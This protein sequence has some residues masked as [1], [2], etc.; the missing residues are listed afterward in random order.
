MAAESGSLQ[1][2]F[3]DALAHEPGADREAYLDRACAG[4]AHLRARLER[5]LA[6]HESAGDFMSAPAT[7]PPPEETPG[8]Q[9]GRYHLLEQIGEGGFG[10]V[11]M[12][13]QTSPVRRRV[14]L[15]IIKLGMDTKQVV[16]RFEAE[17]QALAMMEH[18]NIARVIDA[19]ATNT[20]RPYFVME[21]VKGI[22]ITTYC[23]QEK[24]STRQRLDLF[25]TVCQA[26]EHAHQR[27]II[28]RD[29]K[30]S[31]VMVTVRDGKAVPKVIDFGI[32]KATQA[33][34]TE[35]TLF[36][37]FRQL[38]GT[39]AYMSPEQAD[40][41][42][43]DADTRSDVYSLGVLL[44]ELLTG[45][46]PFDPKEL[47]SAAYD[48]MRRIIREVDPPTP[49]TRLGLNKDTL[50]SVAACRGIE[51]RKLAAVLRGDLDWIVMRSLEKDRDRRY[52]SADALVRDLRR[53][54]DN[55][56]VE[57]RRPTRAYRLRKFIRRN[58][59][60]VLAVTAVVSALLIGSTLATIGLIKA[61]RGERAARTEAIRAEQVAKFLEEMIKG[62]EPAVARGRDTS[63]LRE[64][65]D[66]TAGRVERE[67]QD[68]PLVQGNLWHT[69]ALAY[70]AIGDKKRQA[71][72]LE[73]A[74]E[75]FRA[76]V[77]EVHAKTAVATAQLG[78]TYSVLGDNVK[79]KAIA[80]R[81]VDIARKLNNRDTL[82]TC[83]FNLA[84]ACGK[85]GMGS[86]DA[87]PY[88]REAVELRRQG[89]SPVALADA[90]YYEAFM[91]SESEDSSAILR[92]AL[93][94]HRQ[95]LSN[96][97]PKVASD[98]FLLGQGQLASHQ[99][100]EAAQTLHA[101][102]DLWIKLYDVKHPNRCI[103]ARFYVQALLTAGRF[104][105]AE[106]VVQKERQA[107]PADGGYWNLLVLAKLARG[108]LQAAMEESARA[109]EAHPNT[110]I[111]RHTRAVTALRAGD[112]EEYR[113]VCAAFLQGNRIHYIGQYHPA[114]IA[115]LLP[116]DGKDFERVC[117]IADALGPEP[118]PKHELDGKLAR[119]LADLRRGRFDSAAQWADT[120]ICDCNCHC[121]EEAQGDFIA[122]LAHAGARRGDDARAAFNRGDS[123]LA[124][125]HT[126]I[127]GVIHQG[128]YGNL[129]IANLLRGEAAA[130]LAKLPPPSA[131]TT[132]TTT[133]TTRP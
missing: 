104:D 91:L 121:L 113:R 111:I 55:E 85:Y 5:L 96:D 60:A 123:L 124:L 81:G 94:I 76:S 53:H 132:T 84:S 1:A 43:A 15:K 30:P 51:P 83:L 78:F 64:I 32:A 24:L 61:R 6:A 116:V 79:G 40:T 74:I 103:V 41:L 130:A 28:H 69:L 133:A 90:L 38:I 33:R 80:Q 115:L 95:H 29:L 66:K 87:A 58:R 57:A 72:L 56:P 10:I 49:S 21:L 68:Q 120:V 42:A 52:Q 63:V 93:A 2:L 75:R 101:A 67:L 109:L 122:A 108:D 16:A 3:A 13:E 39:P 128:G 65:L 105:E 47:M 8:S 44:Y 126:E 106:A 86:H 59:L 118:G 7:P 18:E 27:G 19:G 131:A 99:P 89:S 35:R 22:P 112:G 62:I 129:T 45:T 77:G 127:Q 92:E 48:E 100:D 110:Q 98:Y 46:T 71:E 31:N 117:A 50:A 12:A 125:P 9:I 25:M 26:V 70:G 54:L 82:A 88:A 11:F 114:K 37:E 107:D 4:D 14:A 73:R 23:D 34:L 36:T 97:H 102:H 17:R 119:S 20:G